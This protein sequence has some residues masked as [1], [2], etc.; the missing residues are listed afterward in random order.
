MRG[1][2]GAV[3]RLAYKASRRFRRLLCPGY[4]PSASTG[5]DCLAMTA[6][7]AP[8]ARQFEGFPSTTARISIALPRGRSPAFYLRPAPSPSNFNHQGDEPWHR[9]PA[10]LDGDSYVSQYLHA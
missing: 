4:H 1:V 9:L 3:I 8:L 10:G 7:R 2:S 5:H 6:R